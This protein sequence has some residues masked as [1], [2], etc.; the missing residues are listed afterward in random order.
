[1][2]TVSRYLYLAFAP[3]CLAAASPAAA[4]VIRI[5]VSGLAFSPEKIKAHVGDTLAWANKDFV[6]HTATARNKE[7]DIMLPAHST[8][9][10]KLKNPGHINYYCT[11][12]PTM[13][14]EVDVNR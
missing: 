9:T 2:G 8:R 3:L 7:W 11:Y 1:M 5:E 4:E 14:G 12:H 6:A 13:K 10:L